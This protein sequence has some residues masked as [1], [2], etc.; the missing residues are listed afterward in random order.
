MD[1]QLIELKEEFRVKMKENNDLLL[2]QSHLLNKEELYQKK[3]NSILNVL[4]ELDENKLISN[5]EF[6]IKIQKILL[7]TPELSEIILNPKEYSKEEIRTDKEK[8]MED[9]IQEIK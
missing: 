8:L 9:F 2:I 4:L 7:N 1:K 5:E 3:I 6:Q